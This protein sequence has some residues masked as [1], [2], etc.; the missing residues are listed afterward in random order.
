MPA[1]VEKLEGR[2]IRRTPYGVNGNID[3]DQTTIHAEHFDGLR[4]TR[5]SNQTVMSESRSRETRVN[6][7]ETDDD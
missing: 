7:D 3:F 1:G 2:W 4:R 5:T 6:P